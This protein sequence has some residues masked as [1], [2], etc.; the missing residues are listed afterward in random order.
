MGFE[1]RKI[2]MRVLSKASPASAY[3]RDWST[4]T[5][6]QTSKRDR[7]SSKPLNGLVCLRVK[8]RLHQTHVDFNVFHALADTL[9]GSELNHV[10]SSI[11]CG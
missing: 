10:T 5:A 2:A 9:Y 7:L 11:V 6:V 8:L 3:E 1:L 4:F